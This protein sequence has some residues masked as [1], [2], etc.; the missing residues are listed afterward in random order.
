MTAL[1][2]YMSTPALTLALTRTPSR[3]RASEHILALRH[4]PSR[5]V[6]M[7]KYMFHK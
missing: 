5:A 7:L 1:S 2:L 3:R 4:P 6:D